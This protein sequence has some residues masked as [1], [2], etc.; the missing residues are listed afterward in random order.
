MAR[1]RTI[2]IG[3]AAAISLGAGFTAFVPGSLAGMSELATPDPVRAMLEEAPPAPLNPQTRAA[4]VSFM[5]DARASRDLSGSAPAGEEVAFTVSR[6]QVDFAVR[7]R[8]EVASDGGREGRV[9]GLQVSAEAE[10][11]GQRWWIVAGAER[12]TYVVAPS[13][14]FRELNLSHVGGSAAVGDA[15]IGIAFEV[16]EDAYASIGYVQQRRHFRLGTED[17]EEEDHYIGA[18]FR[19]RW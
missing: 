10:T 6:D 4:L 9:F 16:A 11:E 14:G 18:A 13:E 15:H 1:R 7:P 17:W 19:A 8:L 5:P 3:L 2:E 12:E